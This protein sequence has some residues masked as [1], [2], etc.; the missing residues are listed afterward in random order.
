M[1][2]QLLVL[3]ARHVCVWNGVVCQA[4]QEQTVMFST[5][6]YL[7]C[8]AWGSSIGLETH[9]EQSWS[10]NVQSRVVIVSLVVEQV[11]V[12]RT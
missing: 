12:T 4:F 8:Y 10:W 7:P 6:Y 11:R 5:L 2:S 3:D 9:W 1:C